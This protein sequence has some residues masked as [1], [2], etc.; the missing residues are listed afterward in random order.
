M[1]EKSQPPAA[2][3]RK[4]LQTALAIIPSTALATSVVPAALAAE[5]TKNPTRDYVPVFLKTMSGS[6]L[7]RPPM[8]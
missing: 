8:C 4:F 2:S 5:Q 1:K 6:L 7:S 3:R